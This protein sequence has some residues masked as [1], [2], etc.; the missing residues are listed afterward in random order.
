MAC[1]D[2]YSIE[3]HFKLFIIS[4]VSLLV[5][6]NGDIITTSTISGISPF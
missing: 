6:T 2:E 1:G 3:K 5:F 4:K